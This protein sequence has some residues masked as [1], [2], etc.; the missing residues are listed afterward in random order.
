MRLPDVPMGEG[1]CLRKKF[2]MIPCL[3]KQYENTVSLKKVQNAGKFLHPVIRSPDD[4][5]L[6]ERLVD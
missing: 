5:K 2:G 6:K 3:W 1:W 4:N